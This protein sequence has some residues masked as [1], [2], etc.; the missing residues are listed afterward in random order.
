MPSR[1]EN[2]RGRF[3]VA[4]K[5]TAAAARRRLVRDC[6]D[7]LVPPCLP[8]ATPL[9]AARVRS[10]PPV[11]L[12]RMPPAAHKRAES[13]GAPAAVASGKRP[14]VEATSDDVTTP[15]NDDGKGRTTSDVHASDARDGSNLSLTDKPGGS[16]VQPDQRPK[17][18]IE[19]VLAA[20]GTRIPPSGAGHGCLHDVVYPPGWTRDPNARRYDPENPAKAYKFELDT[21]QRK[22]VEVME[23]GE[24]VMVAA[25]TSAGKTVVAEYAIAMSLR[26][27]Q[28]V[29]YTSPLKALSN[30][31]YRELA[32]EFKDVGLMTGDTVINPDASCLVMTTEVLRSMLYKGGE[33]MREVGWVI[34]DE[35]HYMRD[36]DRGVVWEETIAGLPHAVRYAF[37][38]ATIPNAREFAEWIVKLHDQPCHLV[39]TDFRPTPLEHYIFPSGG[40]GVY[41]CY[42]RENTFRQENFLKAI[43]AVAPASDGY[44][45]G[46]VAN[47]GSGDDTGGDAK[48]GKGGSK[49]GAGSDIQKIIK[50][51]TTKNYDPCIVFAFSKNECEQLVEDCDGIDLNNDD[52][53]TMVETIYENALDDLSD[54]DKRLPQVASLL[55]TLRRGIGTH[56]AGL[57]PRLKEIVEILFQEGLLKVLVA[58]ETMSTGLNMPAKTV[59]FTSP[60]KF[61]GNGYR[62]ISSGEYVQMS[63]RAGR[64]GLDD[65]GLVILMIDERMDPKVARDMLHGRSDPLDSAFRL[66]Y[67]T[68]TNL[69]R[70]EGHD[71]ASLARRSFAQF[72]SER[73]VPALEAEAAR[74]ERER[75]DVRLPSATQTH[76]T[77]YVAIEETLATL[78]AERRTIT[79][80][81]K[82]IAPFLSPGRMTRVLVDDPERRAEAARRAGADGGSAALASARVA[83]EWGVLVSHD[84]KPGT[85]VFEVEVLC[86]AEEG[87]GNK[88]ASL[89]RSMRA[90][91]P[92]D[93]L[94]FA[95]DADG[96]EALRIAAET[97]QETKARWQPRVLRVNLTQLDSLSSVRVYLPDNLKASVEARARALASA[98]EVLRRFP[99]GVPP[100]RAEEDMKMD[101]KRFRSLELKIKRLETMASTH[102]LRDDPELPNLLATF[103]RRRELHLAA[104]MA[105]RVARD[106]RGAVKRDELQKR[107]RVLRRLDHLHPDENVALVKG[108]VACEIVCS[109]TGDELVATELMFDGTFKELDV[110]STVALVSALLWREGSGDAEDAV[111]RMSK[112]AQRAY[113]RLQDA[114]RVVA[115]HEADVGL[116][117][118]ES[119]D[120]SSG[121]GVVSRFRPEL[122]DM[123]RRW[124]DGAPF[125]EIMRMANGERK[126]YEGSIVRAFRRVQEFLRSLS[127]GARVVG[128]TELERKFDAAADA[129]IR[130]IVFCDSLFAPK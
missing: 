23:A 31:K 13:S 110:P 50:M 17:T 82:T 59:V 69:T 49:T 19:E 66:T 60:R 14:R 39:Y 113:E 98:R 21:F 125:S 68:I 32:E 54:D 85:N 129:M 42:D 20:G 115:K 99:G 93:P 83:S 35:I 128:E 64:R 119:I 121:S 95:K 101:S 112:E 74:L 11:A 57:L 90:P 25:H 100:L 52:E 45:S 22:S 91:E 120:A 46:R 44:A 73:R 10:V 27:G 41:L 126:M 67:G 116:D 103:A 109:N 37:L 123:A 61:D 3:S 33:V 104:Q 70:L 107:L 76:I 53:K 111:K 9:L 75:D 117:V 36:A 2:I 40:D 56:H 55:P 78:R 127:A 43:N 122:M 4:K 38:S 51:V 114:A 62:W 6:N 92:P 97:F 15:S 24:S 108:K 5:A 71:A 30:Q 48:A 89:I 7:R 28:R 58:T 1:D 79:N 86:V 96:R 47:R 65:R 80:D 77:D 88:G 124:M 12:A 18:D 105:R 130:D 8:T 118:E 26:D 84:R 34:F 102:P 81:P 94:A 16:A 106:A 29:V 72:Q 63:G 87:R